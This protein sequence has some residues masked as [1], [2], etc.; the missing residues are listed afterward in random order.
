ML[1]PS[2]PTLVAD[3]NT[4]TEVQAGETIVI[5]TTFA[6]TDKAFDWAA[7]FITEVRDSNGTTVLV[8]L[9]SGI[10]NASDSV[11]VGASWTPQNSA[12][13]E[14]R[15]FAISSENELVIL[16]PISSSIVMISPSEED[17]FHVIPDSDPPTIIDQDLKVEKVIDRL[18]LPTSMAFLDRD[19]ILVL[20]KE[21]GR[22]RLVSNGVLEPKPVLDVTVEDQSERGLLGIA[23]MNPSSPDR[24]IFLYFTEE[25]DDEVVNSIYRFRWD[26]T[27]NFT[28][29][30]LVLGLP[31]EPGPN[32]DGGK[33]V[34]GPDGM[35]YAV[36]G[37]LNR[38][39]MLQNHRDGPDPDDTSVI[40][41]V[42]HEGHAVDGFLKGD[43]EKYYAY[44]IRNSFGIDFDPLTGI[45]WDTENGRDRYDEINLVEPGFN[46]GWAQVMGPLEKNSATLNDLVRLEGSYYADPVFSWREAQGLTDLEFF[47]STRLGDKYAHNLFAGDINNGNLYFF[48]LNS[49]RTGFEL[50]TVELE[51]LVADN[52]DESEAITFGKGFGGI[53]DIETGPDGYLYILTY[54]G[55][56]YRLV[57]AL[58]S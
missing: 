44:G 16:S 29:G 49:D 17:G 33:M 42:D 3:S 53:T 38:E 11:Q 12:R 19:D 55:S 45:L 18:S 43:L 14:L 24:L 10:V 13:Y 23:V 46:S 27:G 35:L 9:A 25:I 54:D 8:D 28:G 5:A 2:P 31:G 48:T 1:S 56:I 40:L 34:I 21:N 20:Q 15:S 47:N 32:H 26:G 37:D 39:G 36:I 50:S 57:P 58:D 52:D 7:H 4:L 22:V 6:N 51:D 41:R 30:T